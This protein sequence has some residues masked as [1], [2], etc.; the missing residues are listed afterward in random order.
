M[1]WHV[2]T[3]AAHAQEPGRVTGENAKRDGAVSGMCGTH[4]RKR[5]K[6]PTN[7]QRLGGVLVD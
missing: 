4:S 7:K 1:S 6:P 2:P 3:E 5:N